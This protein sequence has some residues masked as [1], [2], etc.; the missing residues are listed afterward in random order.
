MSITKTFTPGEV[1]RC[2][3][4]HRSSV[5]FISTGRGAI[6]TLP[7]FVKKYG[8]RRAFVI[9]DLNTFEAAGNLVEGVLSEAKI[10]FG[11]YIFNSR[12]LEP[13]E[14]S[15]GSA[16]MHFPTDAEI[17]IA[18][19]SGTVNDICKIVSKIAKV[20]YIIVATAPSMDGYASASS[21]VVMDGLK[22]SLNSRC[23]SVIIGDTDVLCR[24]PEKMLISGLGDMLAK[25]VSIAEW[26][27][28]NL[29]NGEYYCEDIAAYIRAALSACVENASGLLLRDEAAIEAVF[30][31][32][33][34]CGAAM[35]Y[36]GLSRP[37]SGVE[38]YISHVWDMRGAE[39][40]TPVSTHG[41]QCAIGTLIAA[42]LYDKLLKIAPS[43]DKA[44]S[45]ARD[46][47]FD[48]WSDELRTFL[49]RSA[50]V[51]IAAEAKDGK[52]DKE[53]HKER[54]EF[55]LAHFDEILAI[56]RE[57]VPAPEKISDLLDSIG[58][59]K[60]PSEIGIE[61]D[62]LPIT[63]KSTKDIRDKYV[64]SRLVWDLGLEEEFSKS[65]IQ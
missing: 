16:V 47:D 1:C 46:F 63:F 10:P 31:G 58:C 53:K 24:A 32:L 39:F 40:G 50:E 38:H 59:P 7:D 56:I 36:A 43:R 12:T 18:I 49:G 57:E 52:Y 51:M 37:A 8:A 60:D 14:E 42:R 25:Y 35:E 41:I 17:L 65:V 33:I 23:P 45:F 27:I 15:V 62:I 64:L 44:L 20:P 13:C 55:I 54:L 11:K 30:E 34:A 21:S 22:V 48:K 3:K 26:R 61:K 28:S 29:I 9:A 5:E 6:R 19:G 4:V 2:G